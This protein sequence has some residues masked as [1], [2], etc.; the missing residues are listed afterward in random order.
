VYYVC[1]IT[2]QPWLSGKEAASARCATVSV[3]S[4]R[5]GLRHVNATRLPD[6]ERPP[7]S[8]VVLSVQFQPITGLSAAHMG[9]LWARLRERFPTVQQQPPLPPARRENLGTF[10]PGVELT[11]EMGSM[12]LLPRLWFISED[13][14]ELVQVQSDR[15]IANWRKVREEDEYPRYEHVR[16]YFDEAFASFVDFITQEDL[17]SIM[18]IQYEV[19]YVNQILAGEGWQRFG[20][21]DR[22][23][24]FWTNADAQPPLEEPESASAALQYLIPS[25]ENANGRL[26]VDIRPSVRQTDER[27]MFAMT[28]TARLLGSEEDDLTALP[29][30][31]AGREHIVRAFAALTNPEMHTIW[32][33]RDVT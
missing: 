15:F 14:T 6:F 7:V 27:Q 4:G 19:I 32:G 30:L 12:P 24:S 25:H 9:L 31:D 11:V 16:A 26:Y 28:L 21:I 2:R 10:P 1:C 8:E 13:E 33:R 17:G 18:P 20:E 23:L 22:V 5:Y 3:A 29:G